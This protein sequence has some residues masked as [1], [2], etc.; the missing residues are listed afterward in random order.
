MKKVK[1]GEY[2]QYTLCT[3]VKIEKMKPFEIILRRV[4][5]EMKGMM[6]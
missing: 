1:V 6:V 5:G 2:C 4:L 3:C